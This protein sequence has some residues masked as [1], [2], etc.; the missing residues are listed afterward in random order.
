MKQASHSAQDRSHWLVIIPI[1]AVVI[2]LYAAMIP[3]ESEDARLWFV[4]WLDIII[5]DG[6]KQALAE[7]MPILAEDTNDKG[8]YSP[9]YLYVLIAGSVFSGTLAS[10]TIVKMMAI[11]G[12]MI[13]A[14][15]MYLLLRVFVSK[16]QAL[17]AAVAML[18]LPTVAMNTAAWGQADVFYSSFLLVLVLAAFKGNWILM[19]AALGAAL[20]FKAQAL[21]ILPFVLYMVLSRRVPIWTFILPAVVYACFMAPAWIAGRPALELAT[22][23]FDQ[24]DTYHR[25]AMDVP[26]PWAFVEY[27]GLLPYS[28]GLV[29]GLT[30]AAIVG[31]GVAA[32]AFRWRLDGTDL[33]L[34][35]VTS[36]ALMPFLLPKMHDRYFFP[37]ELLAFALAV[38]NP[39]WWTV[40]AAIL[41]QLGSSSAY[42]SHLWNFGPGEY[43]GALFMT[44]G[45]VLLVSQLGRVLGIQFETLARRGGL[46]FATRG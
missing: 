46:R 42:G 30:L 40:A 36:T 23:Y 39:K 18:L 12:G 45:V 13:C 4:P 8:N 21:F 20:A 38:V 6:A 31:L 35:A 29:I 37:A 3:H 16:P 22:I 27:F 9:P 33:L 28:V 34:L 5:D 14:L 7:P 2:L 19:M 26:N 43:P 11:A 44:C 17:V 41:L 1:I 32:L 25:L 10:L 15:A 24:A